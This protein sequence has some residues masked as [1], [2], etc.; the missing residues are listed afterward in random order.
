MMEQEA[1][2]EQVTG[3]T[4]G[5]DLGMGMDLGM[6]LGLGVNIVLSCWK[7]NYSVSTC[8]DNP[9]LLLSLSP[10]NIGWFSQSCVECVQSLLVLF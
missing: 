8:S 5:W 7:L 9:F 2:I 6:S 4:V 3:H 10:P 1:G